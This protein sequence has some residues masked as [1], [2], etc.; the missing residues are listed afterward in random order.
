M[1]N[2]LLKKLDL[3]TE[4]TYD[5]R[6][7]TSLDLSFFG[8]LLVFM[9]SLQVIPGFTPPPYPFIDN[10]ELECYSDPDG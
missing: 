5:N 1:S 3:T 9:N 4:A 8:R 6:K 7:L 10:L 2:E